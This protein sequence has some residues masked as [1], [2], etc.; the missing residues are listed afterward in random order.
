MTDHRD[1]DE[2]GGI[3]ERAERTASGARVTESGRHV[4]ESG[5][6]VTESGRHVTESG[7]HVTESGRHVTESGRH[8]TESGRHVTESGRHVTNRNIVP[9]G[10]MSASEHGTQEGSGAWELHGRGA[11]RR[12]EGG[13][14]ELDDVTPVR[15]LPRALGQGEDAPGAH[16][17]TLGA[18]AA[19]A[20][21]AI[22]PDDFDV[23]TRRHT[24]E[25]PALARRPRDAPSG[26]PPGT[27]G[28]RREPAEGGRREPAEGGRREPAED[29]ASRPPRTAR[30]SGSHAAVSVRLDR[31]LRGAAVLA[32][33]GL[34]AVG[35]AQ[36]TSVL[37]G[38]VAW[39]G[40]VFFVLTGWGAIVTRVAR[41]DDPDAGLGAALGAAG[42]LA[43]AGVLIAAGVLTR[44]VVLGLI[45]VGFAGF[46][47]RE[48][49]A[50]RAVWHRVRDGID[51]VRGSPALG[52]LIGVLGLVACV[53]I[54]GA[55]AAL[56]RN[57]W[58]DDIAYT[59]FVKRLLDTGD[60]VE[61][62]SFRRLGAY[63]G[64]TALL[65]LG[66]ARGTLAN[67]HLIDKGLGLLVALL[68][69]VGYARERRTQPVWL[70][71]VA[72]VL[73]VLPDTA[74]NTAS[75]WTGVAAFLALYRSAV[76]A[77]WPLVG[78]VAAATC[79][80]RQNF[81]AV[82]AVFVASVL[83]SR[84]VTLAGTMPLA[85]AWR[86]ERRAWAWVAGVA[87]AV[88]VPWWIAAML[89]NDTF[90]FPIVGGTW[91]HELSLKPAV[92][93]WPQELQFL[94]TCCL[95]TTPIVV[96]PILA[97]VLAFAVDRR[98]GRPLTS[99]AIAATLGF[100]WL[101][102]GFLGSEPFH[103]WRYAFGFATPLAILLV[104]EI[105]AA[106]EARV[107]LPPLG[108]WLVLAALV[109]QVVVG[110]GALPRQV[111][112]LL[113]DVREA[114]AIDRRGDPNARTEQ[115]RYRAMQDAIPPGERAV[116][117]L[118]DPALLDYRRN[119]IA[120]LDTP[121]FASPG[122]QLPA[123]RGA[124]P[125]RAYLVAQGYRY[126]AFV[127][128]ERSRYC[129]RRP[130]WIERM[131]TDA[132]LFQIMSAYTIDAIDSFAELA[133]TTKVRYDDD[134]LVVLDLATPLREAS[135]RLSGDDD[136]GGD[137]P[138]RR[139][140]WVRA[141]ADREG[142]HDAWSLTTRADLRFEDG[143]G[144][145]RY[146]DGSIDDPRWYEVTHAR[147][148]PATRGTAILPVLRR[149]HLR[150]RGFGDMRLVLRAA[151]ALN[152][153]YTHPRLDVSLD[154]ELLASVV[155]D[156][157]GRYAVDVIVPRDRLAD[158]WRDLYLV[159]STIADPEKDV[160]DLRI[161]RLESVE[162]APP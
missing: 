113:D 155:A 86:R 141:L 137:E 142:L 81:L 159:F 152:T 3:P 93:T 14:D 2:A 53:R 139:A 94:V 1:D 43:I 74:I 25:V 124:E 115:R 96:I 111:L 21:R 59:P 70:G 104:L 79:T 31:A 138:T 18:P 48:V 65:A 145:L 146:V 117:M 66:A 136:N 78:L 51:F 46:A 8:V 126:A 19:P 134:G 102:N 27:E 41:T 120:N 12:V 131:F 64:Q 50:P 149:A 106:D 85:D 98:I 67:V 28:E 15:P 40:F 147:P 97:L 76:R 82:V 47:W 34:G 116:V 119:P 54:V 143:T 99:L 17:D 16:G 9:R 29:P 125:L 75:Y 42:Y 89:S 90:L 49:T 156:A 160:R 100:V 114:A 69:M 84:L 11:Y 57:P 88:I 77:R 130:F 121:G 56:D 38:G 103:L 55:V 23:P 6:H 133:T 140:A 109:L 107:A 24:G 151:I 112:A 132:E 73:V 95:E 7:R 36:P 62:F 80:L 158:G 122:P 108:R 153:V 92:T 101:V 161:A 44:P 26:T 127:R 144:A 10:G 110:R 129:F 148:E 105:G 68:A 123:F 4:T 45:G 37:R 83:I 30:P 5:R 91:N 154:G 72:L 118:D 20:G 32:V 22:E 162:W 135:R 63:G 87:L 150:V 58:D 33:L 61:P 39:L 35:L 128:S 60:L 157:T 13:A 52:V 71:L